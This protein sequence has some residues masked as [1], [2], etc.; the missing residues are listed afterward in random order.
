[1]KKIVLRIIIILFIHLT[2]LFPQGL[3]RVAIL[4][5]QAKQVSTAEAEIIGELFRAELVNKN[6]FDVLDRA[7][8]QSILNE[9]A[10]QKSGC[11]EEACA[12]ELG[13]MLNVEYGERHE[14]RTI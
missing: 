8:M 2:V 1:M 13:K 9:Q 3:P 5:F 12:V 14:G 6:K 10:F 7:N 11:T 4:D